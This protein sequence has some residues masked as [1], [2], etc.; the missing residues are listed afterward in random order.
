MLFTEQCS[1]V[2]AVVGAV[3]RKSIH[4][5][6]GSD[7]MKILVGFDMST[8]P[9]KYCPRDKTCSREELPIIGACCHK[10]PHV[11]AGDKM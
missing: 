10:T 1:G 11:A 6:S 2:K 8:T 5:W 4:H 3:C 9:A 7:T